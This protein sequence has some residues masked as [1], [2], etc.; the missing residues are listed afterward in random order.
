[1]HF[2]NQ[3]RLWVIPL[4]RKLK[5][6]TKEEEKIAKELSTQKS[7]IYKLSRGYLRHILS[8]FFNIPPLELPIV[9][10]PGEPPFLQNEL[11]E[12]CIKSPVK[13]LF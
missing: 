8:N 10:L 6:I 11:G 2:D 7:K 12:I 1:M 5:P 3:I 13:M 9:A 4:I